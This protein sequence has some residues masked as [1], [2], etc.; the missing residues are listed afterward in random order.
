[1][2]PTRDLLTDSSE[3][4]LRLRMRSD[5][6]IDRQTYLGRSYWVVKD[7]L[8]LAFYRFEAEE[9]SLLK[10][11]DGQTS[12]AE[13]QR[14]FA[15]NYAPQ[16][17]TSAELQSFLAR[18]HQSSLVVADAAEQGDQLLRRQQERRR[19][20]HL[21]TW[22]NVLC[23]RFGGINPDRLLLWLNGCCGWLLS[24]PAFIASLLLI[25]SSLLLV[26]TQFD[27]FVAR[28][29]GFHTFFAAENWLLLATVLAGTKIL[30]ELGHGVACRRFGGECHEMGFMLLIL[31]PCLYCD[32]SDS[33]MV[34]SKWRR[35]AIGAAGMYVELVLAAICTWV[36]WTSN[37]GLLHYLCLDVMFVCSVSTLLFNINPL[38]RY[39]GYFILSDLLEI[40]NLRQKATAV[41]QRLSSRWFLGLTPPS[42]PFL[43]HRRRWLFL[44][45]AA[46]A[47]VYRWFVV[48]SIL[49]FLYTVFEPLGL[50]VVGQ[51]LVVISLYGLLLVPL[52]QLIRFLH[53]PGRIRQLKTLRMSVALLLVLSLA[54]VI[55]MTPLPYHVSCSF[56][57]QPRGASAVYVDTS[58]TLLKIYVREGQHVRT[59]QPLLALENA[60]VELAILRLLGEREQLAARLSSLQLQAYD[61]E[62][63][64]LEM[65]EVSRS[66]E[67]LDARIE[68]RR[69]DWERLLVRASV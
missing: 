66:I 65:T 2:S 42:D 37:V 69:R 56:H 27:L 30:H 35:A 13:I 58:G 7:P 12:L 64:L 50:Q 49:W 22:S 46:A 48:V 24:W 20:Q 34:R 68:R 21:E 33:W 63:A 57:I 4:P 23:I 59:G 67:S 45:Y 1:M 9:Y 52:W 6:N 54:A 36:W 43:P 19:R 39:D 51:L 26:A 28:L 53:A 41:V 5:L 55:L 16:R 47:T 32:V 61:N 15:Q 17:L 3:R 62:A 10:W 29:P 18:L 44:L 25:C 11:L 38:L 8:N 14:R 31:T 40:P 60:D